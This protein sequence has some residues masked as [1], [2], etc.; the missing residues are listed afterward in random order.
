MGNG[1]H[2]IFVGMRITRYNPYGY[3]ASFLVPTKNFLSLVKMEA[4]ES[5]VNRPQLFQLIAPFWPYN[6]DA[7]KMTTRTILN[8]SGLNE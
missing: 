4:I 7:N 6:V 3:Q 2:V 8:T 1:K 5:R